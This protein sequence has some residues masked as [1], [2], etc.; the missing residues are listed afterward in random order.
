M[1]S[2]QILLQYRLVLLYKKKNKTEMI[3]KLISYLP[4]T[5]VFIQARFNLQ[6]TE[7]SRVKYHPL[8]NTAEL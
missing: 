5:V 7:C 4:Q 6:S 8:N 1:T 2:V 3:E